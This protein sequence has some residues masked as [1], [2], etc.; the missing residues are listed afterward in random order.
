MARQEILDQIS[1]AFG[2]V[3]SYFSN[4]SDAVLEQAW[5]TTVWFSG[6]TVLSAR[7]K[8]LVGNT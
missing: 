1:E 6:D 5:T 2:S 4:M 8:A 7:D 3:P